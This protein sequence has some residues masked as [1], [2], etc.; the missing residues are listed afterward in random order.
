M[1][2]GVAH[3]PE[4]FGAYV[5]TGVLGRGGMGVVYRARHVELGVE[6]A[7]KVI[8]RADGPALARFEREAAHLAR[9]RHENVVRIHEAGVQDGR[10][11]FVMDLLPG[12]SLHATLAAGRPPL[13]HALR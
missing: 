6:R 4:R 10:P 5:I 7:V 13:R 2:R 12:L 8:Q 9:L 3:P 1:L 11:Y